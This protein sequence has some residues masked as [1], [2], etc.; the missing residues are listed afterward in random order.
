MK[1]LSLI[2]LLCATGISAVAQERSEIEVSYRYTRPTIADSAKYSTIDMTLLFNGNSAKYFNRMSEYC[3]SMTSTPEGKR[4]LRQIQMAAWVTQTP[5]GITVDKSKGNAPEKRV[6]TYI[7]TDPANETVTVYD[8]FA[9]ELRTYT[10]PYSEFTWSI[11]PDS[12]AVI[13]GYQCLKAESDY[14]GRHWTVW[15]APEIPAPFG[16]WKL[17]GLPGLIMRAEAD[18]GFAFDI[19]GIES[20]SRDMRD[21]Y[22]KDD[23]EKTD[24]KKAL[25]DEEYYRN[26]MKQMLS[27]RNIKVSG[28]WKDTPKYTSRNSI[29]S[30]Y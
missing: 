4:Q 16:P 18:G 29:E 6:C 14:H 5:E 21:I 9:N 7:F 23:Y 12:V 19:T 27:A 22:S 15:F 24:R 13:S 28:D 8:E 1:K 26:N 3:D 11:D 2:L 20:V 25:A 17:R 30:D 10:E